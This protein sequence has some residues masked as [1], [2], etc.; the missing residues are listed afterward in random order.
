MNYRTSYLRNLTNK[1][2]DYD[3]LTISF[4]CVDGDYKMIDTTTLTTYFSRYN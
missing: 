3:Y 2:S 1:S 4:D